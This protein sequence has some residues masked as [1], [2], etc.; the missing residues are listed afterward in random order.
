VSDVGDLAYGDLV[1]RLGGGVIEQLPISRD[2]SY[3]VHAM[4]RAVS[5]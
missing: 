3:R 1:L 2:G 5:Y 4:L